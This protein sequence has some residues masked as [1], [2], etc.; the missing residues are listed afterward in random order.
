M[1]TQTFRIDASGLHLKYHRESVSEP[2]A[3]MVDDT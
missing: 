3:H 2:A 1:N